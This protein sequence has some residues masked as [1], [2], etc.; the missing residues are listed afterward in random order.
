MKMLQIILSV[1]LISGTAKTSGL[2]T[3]SQKKMVLGYTTA[4][5]GLHA[6]GEAC[7][8]LSSAPKFTYNWNAIIDSDLNIINYPKELINNAKR[9]F[10]S[11]IARAALT[12]SSVMHAPIRSAIGTCM[13]LHPFT[14]MAYSATH[15]LNAPDASFPRLLYSGIIK[16]PRYSLYSFLGARLLSDKY[17][18]YKNNN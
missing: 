3:E 15:Y 7:H 14:N 9:P 11:N 12:T 17:R 16:T 1:A 4:T 18:E 8:K 5:A 2:L 6:V 13:I 10:A